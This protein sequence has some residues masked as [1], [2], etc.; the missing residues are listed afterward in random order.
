MPKAKDPA[1]LPA[2]PGEQLFVRKPMPAP[3]LAASQIRAARA[4]LGVTQ[5]ELAAKLG[6]GTRTLAGWEIGQQRCCG[7][8]CT[9]VL[10]A[11]YELGVIF[12]SGGAGIDGKYKTGGRRAPRGEAVQLLTPAEAWLESEI[13]SD[14]GINPHRR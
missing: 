11:F 5:S 10:A 12:P 1:K 7:E 6:V 2:A 4:L 8:W 13:D 14:I 9:K 3:A